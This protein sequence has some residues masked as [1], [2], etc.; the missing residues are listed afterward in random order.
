MAQEDDTK[1][2]NYI[3]ILLE[4]TIMMVENKSCLHIFGK[5]NGRNLKASTLNTTCIH[6]FS[7]YSFCFTE[8]NITDARIINKSLL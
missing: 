5:E 6:H 8:W 1:E 7:G 4:N 3:C 2:K